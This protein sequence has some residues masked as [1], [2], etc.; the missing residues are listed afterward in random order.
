MLEIS[1]E[2]TIGI[3]LALQFHWLKNF[4]SNWNIVN[5]KLAHMYKLVYHLNLKK[6]HSRLKA[7]MLLY[8]EV[9]TNVEQFLTLHNFAI[10]QL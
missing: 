4:F 3:A 1:K 7:Q 10:L 6:Q 2:K 9:L 8:F 5:L